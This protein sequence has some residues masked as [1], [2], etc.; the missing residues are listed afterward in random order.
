MQAIAMQAITMQAITYS[1]AM[2]GS[3]GSLPR[4]DAPEKGECWHDRVSAR[5]GVG[6]EQWPAESSVGT[7]PAI[8]RRA[9]LGRG[10]VERVDEQHALQSHNYIGHNYVGPSNGLTNSTLCKAAPR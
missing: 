1:Q 2:D 10:A 5:V 6:T 9:R 7:L 3:L 8:E 4:L